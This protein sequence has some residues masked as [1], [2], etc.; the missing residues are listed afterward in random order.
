M[1]ADET[2][3]AA[4]VAP[5]VDQLAT[6]LRMQSVGDLARSAAVKLLIGHVHWLRRDVLLRRTLWWP[7]DENG[8]AMAAIE[9]S[10]VQRL[11]DSDLDEVTEQDV[12]FD[13][14]SEQGVLRVAA[15][16]ANGWLGDTLT[17][18]DRQNVALIVDAVRAAGGAS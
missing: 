14:R 9:W 16:I 17:S 5:T 1:S 12:L 4:D 3:T 8:P 13:S 11:L 10:R 2:M 18:C 7:A 15:S 6:A